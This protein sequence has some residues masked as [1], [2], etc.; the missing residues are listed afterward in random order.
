MLLALFGLPLLCS[1]VRAACP[2]DRPTCCA[3]TGES[4]GCPKG[5][6]F[7]W[8]EANCR[9]GRKHQGNCGS[10]W[11]FAS[12]G[13]ASDR[14]CKRSQNKKNPGR[15]SEMNLLCDPKMISDG[16][17]C[18]GGHSDK[19]MSW[20]A[21]PGIVSQRA[22]KYQW[23]KWMKWNDNNVGSGMCKLKRDTTAEKYSL[24]PG[25]QMATGN[26]WYQYVYVGDKMDTAKKRR[27][28][29]HVKAS[30]YQY[31]SLPFS[32]VL[33]ESFMHSEK[34]WGMVYRPGGERVNRMSCCEVKL[35]RTLPDW[36]CN[37]Q[38]RSSLPGC[39][40]ERS[41]CNNIIGGHAM[42][43]VG[44]GETNTGDEYWWI[45]N[46]WGNGWMDKGFYKQA[47]WD[48]G[49]DWWDMKIVLE[50]STRRRLYAAHAKAARAE[51]KHE[52]AGLW[53]KSVQAGRNL[54]DTRKP[55]ENYI[56]GAPVDVDPGL[57]DIVNLVGAAV[58]C[59]TNVSKG[60]AKTLITGERYDATAEDS[61]N[62]SL[63]VHDVN[64]L[65][66]ELECLQQSGLLSLEGIAIDKIVS[67]KVQ[68]VSGEL[69]SI[70]VRLKIHANATVGGYP[71]LF[72]P[73]K[74]HI[75]KLIELVAVWDAGANVTVG[76][77]ALSSRLFE[78][79]KTVLPGLASGTTILA[80]C[81]SLSA[82]IV[83]G[84]WYMIH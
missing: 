41:K 29:N 22:W 12:A 63:A 23:E 68:V 76:S 26:R 43:V 16:K 15:L 18:N 67:S 42:K 69:Y 45:E 2:T 17:V 84:L 64:Q 10:C 9:V 81:M 36:Y 37:V 56:E 75:I 1:I 33:R 78:E 48:N 13:A 65:M 38:G 35:R 51:G 32:M 55:E 3:D 25:K 40:D 44:W 39:K 11:A 66:P 30:I 49:V 80:P 6:H 79:E 8:K 19:G 46:S 14:L 58:G 61:V 82:T 59:G 71:V 21:W 53:E 20:V 7:Y 72:A 70:V 54:V 52:E 74:G 4:A 31:G 34:C 5:Y 47:M 28:I 50:D 60:L 24:V 73:K 62:V 57:S 77:Y 83:L 27:N